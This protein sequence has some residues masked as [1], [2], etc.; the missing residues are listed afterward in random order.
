MKIELK[1]FADL[2]KYNACDYAAATDMEM[3]EGSIVRDVMHAAGI[4]P[5]EVKMVFVNGQLR[6]PEHPLNEGDRVALA[7]ATGGM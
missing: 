6:G 7:P 1:C 4:A 2:A 3:P 5:Q